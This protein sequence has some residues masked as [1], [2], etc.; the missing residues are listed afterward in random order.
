MSIYTRRDLCYSILDA[1]S[2]PAVSIL[3]VSKKLKYRD[4]NHKT[5]VLS[6]SNAS[7][8]SAE[9]VSAFVRKTS[10]A[11]TRLMRT[12]K[13]VPPSPLFFICVFV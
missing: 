1:G 4:E 8:Q 11:Q 5:I 12:S 6:G 7:E 3:Y 10:R 13:T 2:S 9:P